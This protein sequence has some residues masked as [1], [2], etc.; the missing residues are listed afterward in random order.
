M[1]APTGAR[2]RAPDSGMAWETAAFAGFLLAT[3]GIM[4]ALEGIA[5]LVGDDV[6]TGRPRYF[7]ELDLDTWGWV[8]LGLGVVAT[9]IGGALLMGAPW[10][11]FAALPVAFLAVVASFLFMPY[12]PFWALVVIAFNA[13]VM[14]SLC[15]LIATQ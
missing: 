10:A 8:H 6:F 14:W 7:A 9:V 13:L 11:R 1:T 12:Y 15:R 2:D 3:V 4:Q 5:A